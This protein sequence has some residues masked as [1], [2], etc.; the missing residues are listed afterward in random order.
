MGKLYFLKGPLQ[1]ATAELIGGEI[2]IGRAS[3]NGICIDD[4]SLSDHHAVI[5]R[6]NGECI[7]RDL[8]SARGT[9]VRGNKII[10]VTLE[11][12]DRIA[13]GSVEAEFTTTEVK[14]HMPKTAVLPT[15][16][17]E[18]TWPQ[19]RAA[20]A[21]E[22]SSFKS[23][24]LTLV[25]FVAVVALA[26]AGYWWYQ[27]LS[28]VD[29]IGDA[30]AADNATVAASPAPESA[31][32]QP[33]HYTAAAAL[34]P[35]P[36]PYKVPAAPAPPAAV[37]PAAPAVQPEPAAPAPVATPAP[38]PVKAA[39]APPNPAIQQARLLIAQN[40]HA[41]AV[42]CLDKLIAS[43][44]EPSVAAD[45]Q[46]PLKQ[47]L[48]AQLM[49]LQSVKQQWEAQC[50]PLEDRLKAAQEKVE[51]D[52]KA[53]EEKKAA[54]ARVYEMPGGH[55]R[56][57]YWDNGY[58]YAR[59]WVPNTRKGTGDNS[60]QSAIHELQIKVMLGAQEV[61]KQTDYLNRYRQQMAAL[62]QQIVP[63]QARVAQLDAVLKS[64]PPAPS[65]QP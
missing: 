64:A 9:T 59:R 40:K 37:A 52:T 11:D 54:E 6:Q 31:P 7:L 2:T 35:T 65:P 36:E 28:K 24:V 1:G 48:D 53:L 56:Y 42:A 46:P 62:D 19:R 12:S 63:I 49:S 22:R 3:D 17:H 18:I 60:A 32:A 14:L 43:T 39:S 13:F 58:Y 61:R 55:W 41:D 10:I 26:G 51:Q 21:S 4:E 8:R 27:K 16:P 33:P 44:K 30:P 50:K 38:V 25:Q 45:A 34:P 20:A 5:N 29:P 23:A 47:A 57:S 15:P